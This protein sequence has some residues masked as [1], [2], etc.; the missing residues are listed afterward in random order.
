[1]LFQPRLDFVAHAMHNHV[2]GAT[3][4]STI[5]CNELLEDRALWRLLFWRAL[6]VRQRRDRLRA[7]TESRFVVDLGPKLEEELRARCE[8]L[9]KNVGKKERTRSSPHASMAA[10]MYFA[11]TSALHSRCTPSTPLVSLFESPSRPTSLPRAPG[12]A[13]INDEE[14][15]SNASSEEEMRAW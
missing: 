12:T 2:L 5:L 6:R 11:L 1:M 7:G 13:R 8:T 14:S 4:K 15:V 9:V 3:D 10:A